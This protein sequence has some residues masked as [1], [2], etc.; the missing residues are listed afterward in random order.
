VHSDPR[1][2]EQMI[3]NLLSNAVKYTERGGV[4]L[5]CRR[6]GDKLRIEVWDTGQGIPEGQLKAIFEEFH[7]LNNSARE[8]ERGLGLGLAII[9]RLGDLLGHAIAVRSRPGQGSVFAIEV[10][11]GQEAAAR[12]LVQRQHALEE[13]AS[14]G[15]VILVVEDDPAVREMLQFLLADEG[16]ETMVAGNGRE[17]MDL[18]ARAPRPD[19]VI[20]DYNL[21]DGLNGLQVVARLHEMHHHEIPVIILTGDIST[22]TMSEI[23]R[24]GRAQ[25]K[26]P[27]RLRELM[28]L[29]RQ[30]LS[31]RKP[32]AQAR[33]RPRSDSGT[34][35]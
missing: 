6:R 15:G 11:L 1:L 28:G 24:H 21:P 16:Y 33:A 17:A 23:S 10:P 3:R 22:E 13:S 29:I 35:A 5:G 31:G 34:A 9:Q 7:Q 32:A 14:G 20:A 2:L 25:L 27:V 4:L 19:L 26:K 30:L 18:V 12:P 8:R